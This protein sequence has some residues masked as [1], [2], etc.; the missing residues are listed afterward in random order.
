[1][2]DNVSANS[3]PV[4]TR[5]VTYSG[6]AAQNIQIVAIGILA[7]SDDAKTVTDLAFGQ[8]AMAASI[9]V[10][11]ANNQ[12][13]ILVNP[14]G[15]VAHDA[16][17]TGVNPIPVGGYASAAV[18]ASVSA[19]GDAVRAWFLRNGAQTTVITAAGALVGGDATNGLD[20]DVTRVPTDP[21][22]ANADAASATG[23]FSAKLRKLTESSSTVNS[24]SSDGGTALT[25]AAQVIK[26]SAGELHGYYIYNP[27]T[28]AV[29]VQFY[30][31]AAGSVTVGTTNPLFMITIPPQSAANLWMRPGGV[32]FATAMS[33]AAVMTTAGGNTAPTTALD[34][35]AWYK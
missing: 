27:N 5:S 17:V 7:G 35:V 8:A 33:W 18:P 2:A 16:D 4:A 19:D 13:A 14:A 9:P 15:S 21:F 10:V 22:G 29:Y 11:I 30:N 32:E 1:M 31:T 12:S 26:A 34:A 3:I 20:V 6:D 24:T 23:S 25:N 28:V